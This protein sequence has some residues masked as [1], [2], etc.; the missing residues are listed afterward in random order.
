MVVLTLL[1]AS[2]L[3]QFDHSHA[4]WTELLARNVVWIDNG[5]ASQVRY[6]QFRSDHDKL[7]IYLDGLSA[8]TKA[9]FDGW[10]KPQQLAFLINAYN[11]FTIEKVLTRYPNLSS[12]R[13]FGSLLGNPWKDRF[14][15][16]FGTPTSLDGIEHDTIRKRGVY[17]EPRIHFAVNCAS[18]GCPALRNEAYMAD[19]LDYQLEDQTK[20]FLSDRT[21]NRYVPKSVTLEV[22]RIF[23]WYGADFSSGYRGSESVP[24]FLAR[25]ATELGDLLQDQEVVR[26]GK[27]KIAFLEYDW[28]LNDARK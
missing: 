12:I 26:E 20:R 3:A 9:E 24:S 8:V 17:D 16:L 13:D 18:I 28:T 7:K 10:T 27:V 5:R 25:Y 1:P 19:R 6:A 2:A 22:S 14:F 23:D 15:T 21:R 11:A 4:A